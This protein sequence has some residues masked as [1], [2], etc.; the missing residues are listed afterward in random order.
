MMQ[1]I[2][3][4]ACLWLAEVCLRNTIKGDD[5]RVITFLYGILCL[6]GGIQSFKAIGYETWKEKRRKQTIARGEKYPGLI[7]KNDRVQESGF[8]GHTVIRYKLTIKY[9]DTTYQMERADWNPALVLENPYCDVYEYEGQ[10]VVTNFGVRK[11]YIKE[12]KQILDYAK[13]KAAARDG[14]YEQKEENERKLQEKIKKLNYHYCRPYGG[15]ERYK[16]TIQLYNWSK[17]IIGLVVFLIIGAFVFIQFG[18]GNDEKL[19]LHD[20]VIFFIIAFLVIFAAWL[21]S[22]VMWYIMQYYGNTKC[23]FY[24]DHMCRK[25]YGKPDEIISYEDVSACIPRRKIKIRNGGIIYPYE[26][27]EICVYGDSVTPEFYVFMH[28]KCGIPQL[29]IGETEE[30]IIQNTRGG[31]GIFIWILSWCVFFRMISH[32][33]GK[34]SGLWLFF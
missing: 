24:Q 25:R 34:Y 7:I 6:Y 32:K 15:V 23:M 2:F 3:T 5:F 20:Y 33:S 31:L 10:I 11:E 13:A 19:G 16:H 12:S 14:G 22:R 17:F 18:L 4:I 1:I 8:R 28:E 26:G 27:G 30:K 21:F 9:R 29:L